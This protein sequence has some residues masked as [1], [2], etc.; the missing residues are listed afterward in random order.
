MSPEV[1]KKKNKKKQT[2]KRRKSLK[3][4]YSH[5][6]Q[7]FIATYAR[8]TKKKK[9][10]R[11]LELLLCEVDDRSYQQINRASFESIKYEKK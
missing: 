5:N 11:L 7:R 6:F 3:L 10:A 8:T 9:M 2:Q 1:K 4:N